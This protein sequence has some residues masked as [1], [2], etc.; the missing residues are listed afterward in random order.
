LSNKAEWRQKLSSIEDWS[1]WLSV[2]EESAK[3]DTLRQHS[4]KGLPLKWEAG[5]SDA[6]VSRSCHI[7]RSTVAGC[8]RRATAAGLSWPL[9][10]D[11]G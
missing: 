10:E 5:V 3:L 9:P 6:A 7:S 1:S 11:K 8:I 4:E 2:E